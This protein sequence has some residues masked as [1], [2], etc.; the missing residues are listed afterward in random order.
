[1]V[2]T[3][4]LTKIRRVDQVHIVAG[5]VVILSAVFALILPGFA[6]PNNLADAV[7]S[8]APLG[9]LG[10]AMAIV[11]I[12]GGLDLSLIVIALTSA[13]ITLTVAGTG[14]PLVIAILTGIGSAMAIGLLNGLLVAYLEVPALF[15]TIATA[16][17]VYGVDRLTLLRNENTEV[18]AEA[19]P[20]FDFLSSR[21][22]GVSM[23]V[24]VF[25]GAA[26]V[27]HL[28]LTRTVPGRFLYAK[29]DN[30]GAARLAGIPVRPM[31]LATFVAAA[32]FAAVAGLVIVSQG[33][34]LNSASGF[35]SLV[36]DVITV[37]VIGGI[38]LAGGRGR[39][40]GVVWGALLVG[41]LLN[42]MTLMNLNVDQ[43]TF[44]KA[45]VLLM[46]LVIDA[47]LHPRALEQFKLGDL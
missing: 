38:S 25:A 28:A 22:L 6:S 34:G 23:G 15:A 1:M 2:P 45:G 9:I 32:A 17:M 12:G 26:V 21:L 31:T 35:S 19:R 46:A 42:G 29:G 20:L 44:L 10:L 47:L 11:I 3:S 41:V 36:Y 8:I 5:L 33:N 24:F 4:T 13:G 7:A 27:L 37:A 16:L 30:P 39:V 40:A 18:P 14:A 43:Q